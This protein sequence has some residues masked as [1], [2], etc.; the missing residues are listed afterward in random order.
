MKKYVRN[1][2]HKGHTAMTD[3]STYRMDSI[4]VSGGFLDGMS[5]DFSENMNCIIGARGAGKTS[6]VE[7]LRFCLRCEPGKASDPAARKRFDDIIDGSLGNGHVELGVTSAGGAKYVISRA[8][9]SAPVVYD[10]NR[11]PTGQRLGSAVFSAD[12]FS[13]NEVETIA[14]RPESQLSLL[15]SFDRARLASL[16][17]DIVDA[18]RKLDANYQRT[19]AMLSEIDS[20]EMKCARRAQVEKALAEYKKAGSG[21]S[22]DMDNANELRSQREAEKRQATALSRV[23]A[24]LER[25]VKEFGG[26]LASRPVTAWQEERPRDT[27]NSGIIEEMRTS[28]R[29]CL[30]L[31]EGKLEEIQESLAEGHA[32]YAQAEQRLALAHDAQDAEYMQLAEQAQADRA[33]VEKRMAAERELND[34]LE[35]S[36]DLEDRRRALAEVR[37]ERK[38][39]LRGLEEA[40]E[41]QFAARLAIANRIN[42][43]L[44][45]EIRVEVHQYGNL[46]NYM[47]LVVSRLHKVSANVQY[48]QVAEKV[49]RGIDPATLIGIVRERRTEVLTDAGLNDNQA[50]AVIDAFSSSEAVAALEVVDLPD[51]PVILLR[52]KDTYKPT[53]ILSTG[54]K[55]NAILPIL[56]MDSD[57]PLVIDQPEDNLDNGL[58]H[59]LIVKS[60]L[61]V[62]KHRQLLFVTH[63]PNIPVLG[64]AERMLV[65][66]SDGTHGSIAQCGTVDECKEHIVNLLE[67]GAEAFRR[68]S[69]CYELK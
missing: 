4:R 2:E 45:P 38:A 8:N 41:C 44:G 18:R 7:L 55:C 62:K 3:K 36:A 53:E 52:D 14:G 67:G 68:R 42:D 28:L 25:R 47:A 12:I 6:L 9:G 35:H 66:T 63:N 1:K 32:E 17:A 58:I 11:Q 13:Q 59:S 39:L 37:N 54:Q 56:L 30:S 29:G 61:K 43:E 34:I 46:D 40:L 10:T 19:C 60:I 31:F 48:N 50:K 24:E 15:E 57:R 22:E 27:Q 69:R 49:A 21:V 23:F 16:N 51:R 5:F 26:A 33:V 20:L 65:F 64:E